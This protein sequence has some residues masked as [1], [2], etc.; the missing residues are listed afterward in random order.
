MTCSFKLLGGFGNSRVHTFFELHECFSHGRVERNHRAGTVG[1]AADGAE[2]ETVARECKWRG[3]VAIGVVNEQF[4]DFRNV[5][6]QSLLALHGEQVFLVR[7]LDVVEQF[8]KLL[9][10]ERRDD[11]RRCLVRTQTMSVGGGHDA[12]LEQPIV[13]EDTHQGL[14]DEDGKAQVLFRSL[15]RSVEQHAR[16]GRE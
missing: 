4:R 10:K 3:S 2:L 7:L 1:F 16:V 8:G 5:H 14:D 15:A 6:F 11:G 13:A 9:A 12:C